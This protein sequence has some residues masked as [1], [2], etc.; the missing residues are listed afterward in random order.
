LSGAK[1][2]AVYGRT[3]GSLTLLAITSSTSFND[4]GAAAVTGTDAIPSTPP[5]A[6]L[7]DW[8]VTSIVSGAGSTNLV[9]AVAASNNVTSQFVGHDDTA[10]LNSWIGQCQ[11][12]G[13]TCFLDSGNFYVSSTLAVTNAIRVEGIGLAASTIWAA[14]S[15]VSAINI[16]TPNAV[17]FRTFGIQY[18]RA[19]Y[20][21]TYAIELTAPSGQN[22]ASIFEGMFIGNAFYGFELQSAV[23][24]SILNNWISGSDTATNLSAAGIYFHSLSSC[25][26]GDHSVTGNYIAI[27]GPAIGILIDCG[28][29]FKI[30]GNKIV[31]N[32]SANSYGIQL[33]LSSGAPN[34]GPSDLL[35]T[36][37][38]IENEL[39]G[40]LA[41]RQG[42]TQTY[43]NVQITDNE[44]SGTPNGKVVF[45]P[46]DGT[47]VW[48]KNANISGNIIYG[49]ASGIN[50][51]IS[52]DT[53]S[54]FT[55]DNNIYIGNGGTDTAFTIGSG[56]TNGAVLDNVANNVTTTL[57]NTS[58]TVA[59]LNPSG[60]GW[61]IGT[62]VYFQPS[63]G[64]SIGVNSD[65]GAGGLVLNSYAQSGTT[66]V[67]SLP[68]CN[69][70]RKG[71]RFF[72]TDAT[73]T[74]F[75]STVAGGGANNIG[76]TC[77]GANWYISVNNTWPMLMAG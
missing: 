51:G 59:T 68:A 2:Y 18:A 23:A 12:F 48:L 11:T 8:L 3:T 34:L 44:F 72:V 74:T 30:E 63:G 60:S 61:V 69:S 13:L 66:T 43:F 42:T 45:I 49:A 10:A 35:I 67:S 53:I 32:D 46:T 15:G 20:S 76:V 41:Q 47:G 16:S 52:L 40:F 19:A 37:N 64:V 27:P 70:G 58:S 77:D 54:V 4:T 62:G 55:L 57:S 39:V 38:S 75:H 36:G 56:A 50:N 26:I 24:T 17:V 6:A 7:A 33:S 31:G 25:G 14:G 73:A 22:Y 29:G 65:P 28:A 71:A 1:A 9:L 21:A 5:A